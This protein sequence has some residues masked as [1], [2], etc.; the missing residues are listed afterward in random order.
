MLF[1]LASISKSRSFHIAVMYCDVSPSYC[2]T[3]PAML[4][5]LLLQQNHSL[6]ACNNIVKENSSKLSSENIAPLL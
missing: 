5:T 4:T 3:C 6:T 2:A 1:D